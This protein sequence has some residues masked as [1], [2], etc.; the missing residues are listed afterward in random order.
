MVRKFVFIV[1]A[2]LIV[3]A[4]GFAIYR[5]TRVQTELPPP[6]SSA[7]VEVPVETG[8]PPTPMGGSDSDV[9][10]PSNQPTPAQTTEFATPVP[11]TAPPNSENG[12]KP[13]AAK[14]NHAKTPA[15]KAKPKN[16]PAD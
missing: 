4:A 11:P 10:A 13:D 16:K 3:G 7:K 8:S 5:Y 1:I 15:K 14:G 9:K 6:P 2:A 12:A